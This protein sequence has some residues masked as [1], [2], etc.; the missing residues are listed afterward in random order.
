MIRVERNEDLRVLARERPDPAQK[1][2]LLSFTGIGNRMGGMDVQSPEFFSAGNAFDNILFISDLKRSW[3]NNFDLAA[4]CA[5]LAPYLEGR[6]IYA[7]GNSMGGFLAIASTCHLPVTAVAAFVPQFSVVP[8]LVPEETRWQDY[9]SGISEWRIPSLE[10]RF[11]ATTRYYVF[12]GSTAEEGIHAS[13]FPVQPNLFHARLRP[14]THGLAR[15]LK[16]EGTLRD[17][18]SAVWEGRL[19][20]QGLAKLS[21]RKVEML[22]GGE[23]SGG[24]MLDRLKRLMPRSPGFPLSRKN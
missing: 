9:I 5:R 14:A 11:N 1:R 16:D 12:S 15:A 18:I 23:E 19:D 2:I 21:G 4:L 3:G 13:R 6:E 8:E 17:V 24:A 22:S 7:L 10:G 20:A